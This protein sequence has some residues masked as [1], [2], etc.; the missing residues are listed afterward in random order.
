MVDQIPVFFSDTEIP[1]LNSVK[2]PFPTIVP[3]DIQSAVAIGNHLMQPHIWYKYRQDHPQ[4][5]PLALIDLMDSGNQPGEPLYLR[6]P[7]NHH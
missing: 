1:T 2:R 4:V 7:H 6:N 5:V 3:D